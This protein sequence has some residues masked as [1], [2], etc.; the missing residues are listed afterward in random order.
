MAFLRVSMWVKVLFRVSKQVRA[1][2]VLREGLR[3][4]FIKLWEVRSF[5]RVA[6][7]LGRM[8]LLAMASLMMFW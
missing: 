2:F 6:G 3:S 8:A 4:W 5:V 7:S 1:W